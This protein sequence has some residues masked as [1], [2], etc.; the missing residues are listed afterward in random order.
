[1]KYEL[2]KSLKR[3]NTFSV[4]STTSQIYY[5]ENED[6]LI[7]LANGLPK[8]F[9]ILGDGSN[10]LL[11]SEIAPTIIKP[12]F[13]GIEVHETV[14]GYIISVGASEN[15]H[16][17]VAYCVN[18]NMPGLENLALIPGSVGAAPV[19]NIGAYGVEFS[20][21]CESVEWFDFEKKNTQQLLNKDCKFDY[22][23]SLFKELFKNKGVIT[24]VNL[25]LPKDWQPVLSYGGLNTLPHD[26]SAA[27][28][29]AKVIEIRSRKLPDPSLLPN[30][31]SFFKNPI[32]PI[33]VSQNLLAKFP[34]MPTYE[35]DE[36]HKKIA[37]GWLI[38]A[39]NLKGYKKNGVGVHKDQAL[40]MVN[41]SSERGKD[42][43]ELAQYVQEKVFDKFGVRLEPE[44]RLVAESGESSALFKRT[45]YGENGW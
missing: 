43:L 37:A 13:K 3:L 9:Y 44:V 36:K 6:N 32:V 18:N 38:E 41:Y 30:A 16:D 42:I 19:Q 2:S 21:F 34:Q 10:T 39:A 33:E 26:V 17:L 29:M 45:L 15:W 24:H 5:V 14:D 12:S 31:G 4:E 25:F 7:E 22:R 8:V 28:I 1:M 35:V 40:V 11:V 20:M 27:E 23:N